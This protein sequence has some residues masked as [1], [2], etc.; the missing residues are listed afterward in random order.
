MVHHGIH[1]EQVGKAH[2][3][4]DH[5]HRGEESDNV[6]VHSSRHGPE[7]QGNGGD[8]LHDEDYTHELVGRDGRSSY[9]LAVHRSLLHDGE[10]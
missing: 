5:A 2:L 3:K 6:H 7:G 4:V 9:Q 10:T 1:H 8:N